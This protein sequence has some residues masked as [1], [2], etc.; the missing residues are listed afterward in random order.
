VHNAGP[1]CALSVYL[2]RYRNAWGD[3]QVLLGA[4]GLRVV[5]PINADPSEGMDTLTPVAPHTFRIESSNGF[6]APGELAIFELGPD[7]HAASL[8]VGEH[9]RYR[10]AEW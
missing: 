2:G 8:K 7:G 4:S 6:G 3:S 9:R 5:S 10:V 1:P